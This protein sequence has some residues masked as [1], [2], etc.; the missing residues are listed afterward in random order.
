MKNLFALFCLISM[1]CVDGHAQLSG[2]FTPGGIYTGVR[3][4]NYRGVVAYS[5]KNFRGRAYAI[6]PGQKRSNIAIKSIRVYGGY[7]AKI[8]MQYSQIRNILADM[9]DL[10]WPAL[11]IEA[12]PST[13]Y[14][15]AIL[16]SRADQRGTAWF[17]QMG[18]AY[19]AGH[20]GWYGH[21]PHP[22]LP[23]SISIKGRARVRAS[24]NRN[25]VELSTGDYN[26]PSGINFVQVVSVN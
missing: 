1:L 21:Y 3:D 7:K 17:L 16:Y 25:A 23:K 19:N 13:D 10:Q 14:K 5:Q 9:P 24:G 22:I 11:S 12:I 15:G 4:N 20:P 8:N 2:T 26:F 18:P 6:K